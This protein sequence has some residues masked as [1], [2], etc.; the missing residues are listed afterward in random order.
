M[1]ARKNK[2]GLIAKFNLLSISLVVSTALAVASY[3]VQREWSSRLESMSTQGLAKAAMIAEFSE[4]AVYTRDDEA[5]ASIL[6][7]GQDADT[8]YLGLLAAEK[9]ILTKMRSGDVSEQFPD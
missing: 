4:Y 2:L 9:S 8:S 3:Q 7:I 1:N 6:S 5:L